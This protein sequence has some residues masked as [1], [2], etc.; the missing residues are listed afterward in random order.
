MDAIL[1][2]EWVEALRSGRY[3]QGHGV[4]RSGD[5]YCCLGV[6]CDVIDSDKWMVYPIVDEDGEPCTPAYDYETEDGSIDCT[7]EG[8]LREEIGLHEETVSVLIDMNDNHGK[9][10]QEIADYVE[11]HL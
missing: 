1:K 2:A 10:F 9:D 8:A 6:L 5:E 3:Q 7:I 4:L 11:A